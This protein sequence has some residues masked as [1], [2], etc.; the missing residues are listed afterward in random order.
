MSL[1]GFHY[2]LFIANS[3]Y[4]QIT[5]IMARKIKYAS[6][7]RQRR[8]HAAA[9]ATRRALY[10]PRA[11]RNKRTGGYVGIEKKYRDYNYDESITN[12]ITNATAIAD[13]GPSGVRSG[14]LNGI[15]QGDTEQ[16]RI[17]R[18]TY[19]KSIHIK[20]II[21]FAATVATAV[22]PISHKVRL[23][24]V[25][26]KQANGATISAASVLE[27]RTGTLQD[28]NAHYNLENTSRFIILRDFTM[29]EGV[30]PGVGD[31]SGNY[32]K[33]ATVKSFSI[34]HTFTRPLKCL[35][36][37]NLATYATIA[38]NQVHLIAIADNVASR[39][40]YVSRVRFY[41]P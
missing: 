30:N 11:S 31:G 25:I 16:E 18:V 4:I 23:I 20:G 24:L 36:V 15:A 13:P 6:K 38:T 34:D 5:I 39:L 33:S 37:G 8:Y 21:Q 14:P 12:E 35:H 1:R 28:T 32:A 27:D 22:S 19:L 9:E 40:R 41:D 3:K 2:G 10:G 29:D 7:K 17:G 26:D